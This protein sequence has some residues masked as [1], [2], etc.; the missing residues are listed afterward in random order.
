[1]HPD[2]VKYITQNNISYQSEF[3]KVCHNNLDVLPFLYQNSDCV[4]PGF[5]RPINKEKKAQWK[6]NVYEA[7]GTIL[8]DNTF[9]RHIW[10]F[11]SMNKAYSGGKSGMWSASGL[12]KFELAHIFGHKQNERGLEKEVFFDF[13]EKIQPYGLF[14]SASN[15]VLIPKGF[16]KPTDHMKN[17]KV[18]FYKR[19]IELYGNNLVGI[20]DLNEFNIPEWYNEI[21]WLEPILPK[22]W[23]V[24]I[25]NLLKYR[26]K[27]LKHKYA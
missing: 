11:L 10:A 16:A 24:K 6:N 19:H 20:S 23:K 9:P 25:D 12:D 5:R 18:C 8:N 17:I 21:Q 27:Y 15:I 26:E 2:I 13:D 22:D 1:M 7:D 14:T 3:E 4:F